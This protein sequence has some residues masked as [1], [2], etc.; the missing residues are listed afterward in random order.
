MNHL[1]VILAMIAEIYHAI[2][3]NLPSR[4]GPKP[5]ISDLAVIKL[6]ILKHLLGFRHESSFLRF[7]QNLKLKP[8]FP[9][10]PERSRFNRRSKALAPVIEMIQFE[11]LQRLGADD[12]K[13]RIIDTT[14]LPI[15]KL[16]RRNQSQI[17]RKN[18]LKV[19]YC[20]SQKYYYIGL[21]LSLSVNLE[22]VPTHFDFHPANNH[23]L[24]TLI[25][26]AGKLKG[27]VLVGDK[28]YVSQP[29]KENLKNNYRITVIT[30]KRKNQKDQTQTNEG[31]RLLRNRKLIERTI[32][33]LKDQFNL[34]KLS[35][36][37][38]NGFKE[39]VR[40]IILTYT[41]GIYF[42]KQTNR[43]ILSIKSIL[44]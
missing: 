36:K 32:N 38:L 6:I 8:F 35:A 5:E 39:R 9:R 10:L 26:D 22:G 18:D 23:D 42:N 20:S 37:S 31:R 19:G 33:Q 24:K 40:Q 13:V 34:E 21:K 1:K 11:L 41:F 7:I 3:N 14:P 4:P 16:A 15:V 17:V 29:A 30:P 44:T 28:G 25:R 43:N 27:L 2:E 12:F